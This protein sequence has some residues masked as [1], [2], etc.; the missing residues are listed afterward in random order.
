MKKA[1]K[2]V[3]MVLFALP[4][5]AFT[6]CGDEDEPDN[7]LKFKDY[8]VLLNKDRK[9]I[10]EKQMKDCTPYYQNLDGIFY[11][12]D[13]NDLGQYINEV[14]CYFTFEDLE[15]NP[16]AVPEEKCVWVDTEM[17]GVNAADLMNYLTDKYGK[18]AAE[19]DDMDSY[20]FTKG[21]MYVWYDIDA[22]EGVCY[23]GY[24][25]KKSYD[26]YNNGNAQNIRKALKAR[27]AAK[28]AAR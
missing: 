18:A 6:A 11:D 3:W 24:V 23:V 8:S 5:V 22:E 21:N 13:G 12:N 7:G 20:T 27:R 1:M 17:S 14:D 26:D 16:S 15:E 28:R 10:L 9:D 4:M 25:N 2:L 19:N